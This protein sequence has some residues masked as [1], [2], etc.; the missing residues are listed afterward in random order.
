MRGRS[1]ARP[2]SWPFL[3]LLGLRL[4]QSSYIF[5]LALVHVLPCYRS[6]DA[7]DVVRSLNCSQRYRWTSKLAE[8]IKDTPGDPSASSPYKSEQ[9]YHPAVQ[10]SHQRKGK[11]QGKQEV[12]SR[13]NLPTYDQEQCRLTAVAMNGC[14]EGSAACVGA[15]HLIEDDM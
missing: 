2:F 13:A 5:A 3:F 4:G 15:C 12:S 6:V 1:F 14:A 9:P 7:E 11:Q 10:H 8:V